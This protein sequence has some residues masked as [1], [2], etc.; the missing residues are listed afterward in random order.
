MN[1][2]VW[3]C[4]V[5]PKGKIVLVATTETLSLFER[6]FYPVDVCS[7]WVRTRRQ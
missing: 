5:K 7:L 6:E 4:Y 1:T 2:L 3:K